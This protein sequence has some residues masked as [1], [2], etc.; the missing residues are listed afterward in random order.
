MALIYCYFGKSFSIKL[1]VPLVLIWVP[2]DVFRQMSPRL[3][4]FVLKIFGW[5]MRDN[6]YRHLSGMSYLFVAGLVL[7][8]FPPP[9]VILSLLFLAFA[10]PIASYFGIRFGKDRIVGNKTLQGTSAGFVVCTLIAAIYYYQNNI[11]IERIYIVSPLS[12]L[13]GAL[14]ELIPIG[15]LDDNFTFPVLCALFLTILFYLFGGFGL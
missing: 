13:I 2:L 10:D 3:N 4:S 11:M 15:K 8:F 5:V 1:L 14:S 9:V 12:G 7:L 6:E